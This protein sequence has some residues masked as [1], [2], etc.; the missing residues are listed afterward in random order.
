M[1]STDGQLIASASKEV[2]N[3]VGPEL[4]LWTSASLIWELSPVC[5]VALLLL[6]LGL[7]FR[8]IYV[9][10][11]ILRSVNAPEWADH[12]QPLLKDGLT[13]MF[14]LIPH[15][16]SMYV[17]TIVFLVFGLA[18]QLT[19]IWLWILGGV[20]AIGWRWLVMMIAARHT[21]YLYGEHQLEIIRLDYHVCLPY[22]DIKAVRVHHSALQKWPPRILYPYGALIAAVR[23]RDYVLIDRK[24]PSGFMPDFTRQVF[25]TPTDLATTVGYLTSKLSAYPNP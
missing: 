25:L 12:P 3:H 21:Y 13:I 5:H 11:Q 2:I 10:R 23:M 16:L 9:A 14:W 18:L 20:V 15:W 17:A 19:T 8:R 1:R 4:L 6:L 22:A 24:M 7:L